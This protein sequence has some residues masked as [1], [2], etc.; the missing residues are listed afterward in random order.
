M[1][2]RFMIFNVDVW[3]A[4]AATRNV[5]LLMLM[6]YILTRVFEN[7]CDYNRTHA[8]PPPPPP[9]QDRGAAQIANYKQ[10]QPC[11]V[12]SDLGDRAISCGLCPPFSPDLNTCEFQRIKMFRFSNKSRTEDDLKEESRSWVL[13]FTNRT[14]TCNKQCIC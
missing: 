8:F 4:M 11:I 9:H 13:N 6:C 7:L 3:C 12:C 5:F 2:F 1:K 14:A 10:Y